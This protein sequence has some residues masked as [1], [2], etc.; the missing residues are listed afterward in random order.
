MNFW[1][2]RG[3]AQEPGYFPFGS[4][5]VWDML[6]RKIN[7]NQITVRAYNN[8]PD[9]AIVGEYG[10]FGS[11]ILVVRDLDLAKRLLIKDFDYFV[12]RSPEPLSSPHTKN[13]KIISK[14]LFALRGNEWKKTRANFTPVFTSGKLKSMIPLMHK[15]ADKCDIS[16]E[17]LCGKDVEG[18][19]FM[20]KFALDVIVSTGFGYEINSFEDTNN[21]FVKNS[22]LLISKELTIPKMLT[23]LIITLAPSLSKLLDIP[24][25][26]EK[27]LKFFTEMIYQSI[28]ERQKSGIKRND[29]IDLVQ[30]VTMKE[31]EKTKEKEEEDN[32]QTNKELKDVLVING[33]VLFLAGFETVSST[34]GIVLYHLAKNPDHQEKL[35][36]EISKAVEDFGDENLDYSIIM[37][38]KYLEMCLQESQRA[39]PLFHIE[40]GSIKDYKIPETDTIIPKGII[41]RFPTNATT[42]DAKYFPNPDAFNPEN[43]NAE[44]KAKRHAF[45]FGPFGHGPRNCIAERFAKMEVKLAIARIIYKFKLL[46]CEKT[47]D[48]LIPDPKSR[49]RQPLGGVWFSP[50]KRK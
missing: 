29:F 45:A 9:E 34:A 21:V 26:D 38:L 44:N 17:E 33:I 47:V 48:Q 8:H 31:E 43:F 12:D 2:R 10:F 49:S 22:D 1:K 30:D 19:D 25:L 13:N 39:Y 46:P 37:N 32:Q 27:A 15:V 18:K 20:K 28:D 4:Q 40:R 6:T 11:P 36:Q 42:K 41:V 35:F 3:V 16:L 5:D 14:M 23:F 7:F 50:Q 24:V